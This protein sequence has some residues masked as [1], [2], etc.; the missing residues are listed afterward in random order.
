VITEDGKLHYLDM[1]AKSN[2]K[3]LRQIQ[4]RSI[5]E[6]FL[7]PDKP[8]Y[9]N[10]GV[11]SDI[12]GLGKTIQYVMSMVNLE[13]PFTKREEIQFQKIISKCL[14]QRQR[15]AYQQVSDIQKH[16]PIY[17]TKEVHQRKNQ[18]KILL[19]FAGAMCLAG[20]G[21]MGITTLSGRNAHA[22]LEQNIDPEAALSEDANMQQGEM[23]G[24]IK[25]NVLNGTQDGSDVDAMLTTTEA[26]RELALTYL[27]EL[28]DGEKSLEYLSMIEEQDTV[29]EDL[30]VLVKA[31]LSQ[32][33]VNTEELKEHLEHLEKTIPEDNAEKY[34]WC[35]VKG[36][37]RISLQTEGTADEEEVEEK[38]EDEEDAAK[39]VSEEKVADEEVSEENVTDE[40]DKEEAAKKATEEV[41]DEED[42]EEADEKV[43]EEVSD[44]AREVIRLGEMYLVFAQ[45][46]TGTVGYRVDSGVDKDLE[47]TEKEI[48]QDTE[49][50]ANGKE[51]D[52]EDVEEKKKAEAEDIDAEDTDEEVDEEEV[53]E[54]NK[55]VDVGMDVE[56][57]ADAVINKGIQE[58]TEAMACAYEQLGK[59]E[60]AADMYATVLEITTEIEKRE[61]LYKKISML[62]ESCGQTD[63]ALDICV[64]GVKDC[65]DS[66]EL[67]I[68][69]IWLLCK[70]TAIDRDLCAETIRNYIA[71]DEEILKNEEFVK[72][73]KE[74]ESRVEG[75]E[76]WVGR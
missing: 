70:D 59:K 38:M 45:K 57:G 14:N 9:Q 43:S 60:K 42:R 22:A 18:K 75:E 66:M 35:L 58:V 69:H 27:L 64:Q 20:A 61:A 41:S 31:L 55:E 49:E 73:Q 52:K 17:K 39:K 33:S 4:R 67:K 53:I 24:E 6:H 5:R 76:V 23:Q 72:L 12:Y 10:A 48:K 36:Y 51:E 16:I 28:E 21:Y 30:S 63:Q 46:E 19:I 25:E 2:E 1:E 71:E 65:K 15:G 44:A 62:Y 40:K 50:D 8:Y 54:K 3:L 47:E 11:D 7:P 32:K 68:T 37:A 26:Y 34:Y 13:P 29:A 74:Y 56:V